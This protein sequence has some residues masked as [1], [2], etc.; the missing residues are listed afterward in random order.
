MKLLYSRS[1]LLRRNDIVSNLF[2]RHSLV[3]S[4]ELNKDNKY[5]EY[6][7]HFVVSEL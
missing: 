3:I 7:A 2:F 4:F 6:V 5:G 1:S